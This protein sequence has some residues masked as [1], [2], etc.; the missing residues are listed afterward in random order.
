MTT[1]HSTSK[2]LLGKNSKI[3]K[4]DC[5]QICLSDLKV[6]DRILCRNG[7]T[8]VLD[9]SKE[10]VEELVFVSALDIEPI[11]CSEDY[12]VCTYASIPA[13]KDLEIGNH[14]L[15][16]DFSPHMV[17]EVKTYEYRDEAYKITLF[18]NHL[19]YIN[20]VLL[21]NENIDIIEEEE[22]ESIIYCFCGE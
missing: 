20:G 4:E 16:I 17:D 8:S 13:A 14:L 21:G 3:T 11:L 12:R 9:I 18:Q 10:W 1:I 19:F 6:G 7:A 5:K 2:Y 22:E 15:D